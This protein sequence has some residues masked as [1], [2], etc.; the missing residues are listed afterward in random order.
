MCA[1]VCF[2]VL[3]IAS[4]PLRVCALC[5]AS[6][7]TPALYV[8]CAGPADMGLSL[9]YHVKHNY[10]LPAML[11]SSDMEPVYTTVVEVRHRL[12]LAAAWQAQGQGGILHY[13]A[14]C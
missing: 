3:L 11:A 2:G 9:G 14:C 4:W 8:L 1:G 6:G 12:R 10:D 5:G 7:L 13:P